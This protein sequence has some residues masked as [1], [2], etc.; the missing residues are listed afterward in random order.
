MTTSRKLISF[1]GAAHFEWSAFTLHS[2][3]EMPSYKN[4]DSKFTV[5]RGIGSHDNVLDQLLGQ[6]LLGACRA[7]AKIGTSFL[8]TFHCRPDSFCIPLIRQAQMDA[9]PAKVGNIVPSCG[10]VPEDPEEGFNVRA[11]AWR[12]GRSW[13]IAEHQRGKL[14]PQP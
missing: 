2:H 8:G 10:R 3:E 14:M 4:L 9:C 1:S 12:Q 7:T 5:A 13:V 11:R 6:Q